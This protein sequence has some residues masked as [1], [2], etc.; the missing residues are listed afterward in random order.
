[1]LAPL[2]LGEHFTDTPLG[3][4]PLAPSLALLV[5]G[6]AMLARSQLLLALMEGERGEQRQRLGIQPL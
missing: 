5:G 4:V 3:G 2:L 6:A 1:M